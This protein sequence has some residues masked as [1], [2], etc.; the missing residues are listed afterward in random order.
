MDYQR[1]LAGKEKT[2]PIFK[3]VVAALENPRSFPDLVEPI[4]REAMTL[5]DETLDRFR[6]SLMR[7]QIYADVHRN[8]DLEQAM[9]IRYVAQVIEKVVFGSLIMEPAEPLAD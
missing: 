7:L 8:E 5:D 1:I 4:Y 9:H 6:F 3:A 2:L